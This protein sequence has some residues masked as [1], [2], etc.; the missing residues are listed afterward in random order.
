MINARKYLTVVVFAAFFAAMAT[1]SCDNDEKN[2]AVT[3]VELNETYIELVPGNVFNLIATVKPDNATNKTVNWSSANDEV[4]EVDQSGKVTAKAEGQT[5]IMAKPE[6]GAIQPATCIVKVEF[7]FVTVQGITVQPDFVLF[8]SIGE[9]ATLNFATTPANATTQT[10]S[11]SIVAGQPTNVVSISNA[12]VITALTNGETK[13]M[14]TSAEGNGQFFDVCD[15]MVHV[16]VTGVE[17]QSKLNLEVNDATTLNAT[18]LPASAAITNVNWTSSN[19]A[20]AT[21]VN[22]Q[23]IALQKGVTTIRAASADN[24]D[25]F[26]QCEVTVGVY[27]DLDRT[28]W[29]AAPETRISNNEPLVNAGIVTVDNKNRS[30]YLSHKLP[31]D[32]RVDITNVQGADGLNNPSA[33]F[34]NDS[35]TYLMMVKGIG[36]RGEAGGIIHTLG[37]VRIDAVGEKP[38]FIIR[39]SQT[40]PQQFNAFRI[41]YR[42]SSPI[43]NV[44]MKPRALL[45]LGSN[46]D[47]CLTN[48]SAWTLISDQAVELPNSELNTQYDAARIPSTAGIFNNATGYNVET[49][50]VYL[51]NTG[52]YRYIKVIFDRWWTQHPSGEG[53][54]LQIAEFWL[55]NFE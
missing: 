5:V 48:E 24:A 36:G 1:N 37:G 32:N 21:V 33:H 25:I 45:I 26:A 55:G 50:N 2:I 6:D 29:F 14:V 44:Q 51:Y 3:G 41:R 16:P 46:N 11:W 52:N 39:L 13:V 31:Y 12:G 28:N 7:G 34:D 23:V 9:Q 38:W 8:E 53:N 54:T 35:R 42:E 40:E 49:G 4:A 10:V 30:P 19:P 47:D 17:L 27:T 15:I 22:G 18:V 43:P 20:V